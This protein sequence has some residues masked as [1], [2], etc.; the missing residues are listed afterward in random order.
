MPVAPWSFFSDPANVSML[1]ENA[2][3]LFGFGMNVDPGVAQFGK[4]Q[5]VPAAVLA[6]QNLEMLKDEASHPLTYTSG[7]IQHRLL[8][9]RALGS[10]LPADPIGTAVQRLDGAGQAMG[11]AAGQGGGGAPQ[12]GGGAAPQAN[13]LQNDIQSIVNCFTGAR[14]SMEWCGVVVCFQP[15][16]AKTV[17]GILNKATGTLLAGGIA[18]LMAFIAKGLAAGISAALAAWGGWVMAGILVSAAYWALMISLNMTP[19]GVCLHIPGPWTFGLLGPGW[20]VG[21]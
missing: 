4:F 6:P 16:C 2:W 12:G 15:D 21:S 11:A 3:K 5:N 9:L 18:G 7:R 13:Q 10:G 19:R 17:Q 14:W 20:A 1:D 8:A